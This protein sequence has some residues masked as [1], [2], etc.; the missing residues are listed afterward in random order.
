[1]W[2]G[3][4]SDTPGAVPVRAAVVCS[5]VASPSLSPETFQNEP[6]Q[7]GLQHSPQQPAPCS[8]ELEHQTKLW[9]EK[10]VSGTQSGTPVS[11]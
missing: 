5:P 10:M 1:M 4:C 7:R 3:P 9:E 11:A 2:L 8:P 6:K